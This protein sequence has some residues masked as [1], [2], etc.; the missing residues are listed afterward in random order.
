[1][2]NLQNNETDRWGCLP[3]PEL[4]I[5]LLLENPFCY[6]YTPL[7]SKLYT[8]CYALVMLNVVLGSLYP[9]Q[10]QQRTVAKHNSIISLHMH[11]SISPYTFQRY[12]DNPSDCLDS[13]SS[14][15]IAQVKDFWLL[16]ALP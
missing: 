15:Y 7:Y 5:L 10:L 16:L 14:L 3:V 9:L 2:V 1:M 4:A 11:Y 12:C 6:I 13:T 8:M